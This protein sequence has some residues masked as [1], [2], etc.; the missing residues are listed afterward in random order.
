MNADRFSEVTIDADKSKAKDHRVPVEVK[1]V[2]SHTK[3]LR[4]GGGY[5]TDTGVRGSLTYADVDALSLGHRFDAQLIASEI[6]QGL[7]A[8][9]I[10]PSA[11][12]IDSFYGLVGTLQ[13]EYQP[14]LPYSEDLSGIAEGKTIR[15]WKDRH[16]LCPVQKENSEA[17]DQTTNAFL[18]MPGMR[19]TGR[20]YDNM[21]R[22]T[23]GYRYLMEM[24]GTDQAFGS[25]TGFVQFWPTETFILPLPWRFSLVARS[26]LGRLTEPGCSRAADFGPLLCGWRPKRARDMLTGRLAPR[27]K[28]GT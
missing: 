23:K 15:H 28:A 21:T 14:D 1:L 7:A 17:G 16:I 19:L 18:L 4:A 24:R 6:L 10:V 3:R 20:T 9:Y 22:P 13:T 27:M 5:G 25:D 2:P 12:D 8:S 11:T 26:Q